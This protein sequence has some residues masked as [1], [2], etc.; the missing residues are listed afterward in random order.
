MAIDLSTMLEMSRWGRMVAFAIAF[1]E[2][3]LWAW[4]LLRF[5]VIMAEPKGMD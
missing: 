1:K 3:E 5:T 2:E 4:S